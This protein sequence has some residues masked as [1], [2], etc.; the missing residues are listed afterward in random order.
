MPLAALKRSMLLSSQMITLNEKD[1][2]IIQQGNKINVMI[3]KSITPN[4]K[5]NVIIQPDG[6]W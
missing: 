5:E 1:L 3:R 6:R 2:V 4:E